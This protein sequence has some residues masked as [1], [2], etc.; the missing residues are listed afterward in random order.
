MAR[1]KVKV[2]RVRVRVT[3][4]HSR[5]GR[6]QLGRSLQCPLTKVQRERGI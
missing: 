5:F 3:W 1:V 6:G 2:E 4:L